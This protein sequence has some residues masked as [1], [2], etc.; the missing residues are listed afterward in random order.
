MCR[1]MF[2][3]VL[4]SLP[5]GTFNRTW[6]ITYLDYSEQ[7]WDSEMFLWISMVYLYKLDY[8]SF[9]MILDVFWLVFGITFPTSEMGNP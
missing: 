2:M 6:I 9:V 8:H 1:D 4:G 3:L 5:S 7:G